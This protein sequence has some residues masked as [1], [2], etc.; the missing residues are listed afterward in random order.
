MGLAPSICRPGDCF[1]ILPPVKI[2][3]VLLPSCP[4]ALC[5]PGAIAVTHSVLLCLSAGLPSAT[6]KDTK[7]VNIY[8]ERVITQLFLTLISLVLNFNNATRN[9]DTMNLP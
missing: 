7:K 2:S 8:L 3:Y 1:H 4:C 9:S 5:D 6:N